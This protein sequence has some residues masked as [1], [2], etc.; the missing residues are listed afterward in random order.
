MSLR[1]TFW[2]QGGQGGRGLHAG[3]AGRSLWK[4]GG[5]GGRGPHAGMAGRSQCLMR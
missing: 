1:K 5:Q 2:K 4:Q 3:R